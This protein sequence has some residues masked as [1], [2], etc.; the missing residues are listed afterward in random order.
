MAAK[1]NWRPTTICMW[2]VLV[3]TAMTPTHVLI[4]LN[5]LEC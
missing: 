3:A 2:L 5:C 4:N 1:V